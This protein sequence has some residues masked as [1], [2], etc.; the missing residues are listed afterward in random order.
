METCLLPA[1]AEG[2][3]RAAGLLQAGE[4]VGIPTETV[5]GLA[6]NAWDEEAVRRIF[7]A[8]GRPQDNPLIVHIAD[9]EMLYEVAARV[10]EQALALA[11]AFWPGPL[12]I[13]LPRGPQGGRRG[14]RRAG[15]GGHPDAQP[16]RRPGGNPGQRAAAGRPLRQPVRG[17]QPH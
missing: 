7:V 2:V 12:T 4:V 16:S 10:P 11:D 1:N 3:R 6:A 14:L 13:I 8:K 15:H 9:R 5:Y 17:A